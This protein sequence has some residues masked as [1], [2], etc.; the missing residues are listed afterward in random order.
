M[1]FRERLRDLF[2]SASDETST[3]GGPVGS[4]SV[5]SAPRSADVAWP[6]RGEAVAEDARRQ[7]DPERAYDGRE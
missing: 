5:E 3:R 1:P 4:S 6:S 2:G 7:G